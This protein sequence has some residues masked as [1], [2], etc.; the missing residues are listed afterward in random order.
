MRYKD[1]LKRPNVAKQLISERELLLSQLT[2]VIRGLKEDFAVLLCSQR[3][4]EGSSN[5]FSYRSE[6]GLA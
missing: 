1:L 4:N 6:A 3:C 5:N 2:I